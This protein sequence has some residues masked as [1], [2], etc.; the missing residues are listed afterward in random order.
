MRTLGKFGSCKACPTVTRVTGMLNT[1]FLLRVI[2]GSGSE[3]ATPK[4]GHCRARLYD[5][6]ASR[7]SGSVHEGGA[8]LAEVA[9]GEPPRGGDRSGAKLDS[10]VK[11]KLP[12]PYAGNTGRGYRMRRIITIF[13]ELIVL[14]LN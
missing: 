11:K 2:P 1:F 8:V 6:R 12:C 3:R 9:R 13:D 14:K 5:R 10:K 7:A 4:H